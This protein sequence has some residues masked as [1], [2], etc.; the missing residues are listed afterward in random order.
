MSKV[1]KVN[2]LSKEDALYEA[3]QEMFGPDVKK[4]HQDDCDYCKDH[5]WDTHPEKTTEAAKESQYRDHMAEYGPAT[6]RDHTKECEK[7][8]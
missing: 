6:G 7:C 8:K 3:H 2:Q 5:N 4:V 1:K